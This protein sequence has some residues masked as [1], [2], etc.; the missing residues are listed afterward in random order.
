MC[1]FLFLLS[2]L[3]DLLI[4]MLAKEI[5]Q[6]ICNPAKENL[7][8]IKENMFL[9]FPLTYFCSIVYQKCICSSFVENSYI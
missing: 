7:D 8:E 4:S 1:S 5:D 2:K 9:R 3:R 6:I